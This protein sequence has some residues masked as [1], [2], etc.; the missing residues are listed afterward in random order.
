MESHFKFHSLF[1]FYELPKLGNF[2]IVR[3]LYAY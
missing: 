2:F 3:N 1:N